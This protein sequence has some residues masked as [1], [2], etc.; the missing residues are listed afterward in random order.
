VAELNLGDDRVTADLIWLCAKDDKYTAAMQSL[1]GNEPNTDNT[2]RRL[3]D[4]NLIHLAVKACGNRPGIF[5]KLKKAVDSCGTDVKKALVEF[6]AH[7][8]GAFERFYDAMVKHSSIKITKDLVEGFK[9]NEGAV[10]VMQDLV[11]HGV[12]GKLITAELINLCAKDSEFL[13]ELKTQLSNCNDNAEAKEAVITLFTSAD[14]DKRAQF[15]SLG[16]PAAALTVKL[17]NWAS[18]VPPISRSLKLRLSIM[19]QT[20]KQRKRWQYSSR[21]IRKI[22]FNFAS[23]WKGE[24]LTPQ[25]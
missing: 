3:V 24:S 14:A 12:P 4:V 2:I 16:I 11:E 13:G 22:V 1:M 7:S 17:V 19:A 25:Q 21:A 23:G 20:R 15:N 10:G 8:P 5:D 18:P 6:F 9:N